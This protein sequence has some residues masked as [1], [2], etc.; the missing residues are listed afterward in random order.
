[1]FEFSETRLQKVS[2]HRVGNKTNN[3]DLILSKSE[4]DANDSMVRS[5]LSKYFLSSFTIPEFYSFT[6][7]NEDFQLNPLFIYATQIFQG[8]SFHLNSINIAKHLF[9]LSLHPQIKSGDVFVAYFNEVNVSGEITDAIGIFKS[10]NKQAF[11]RLNAGNDGF[12]INWEEGI[13][14]EKLDK[15][16]LILNSNQEHGLKICMV[17]KTSKGND[18]QFWK[19][20]FLQIKPI[21]DEY[22]QTKAF[23]DLTKNFVTKQ[24]QQDFEVTKADQIDL[25]N[26]SVAYFKT[27]DNFD[28]LDFEKEVFQDEAMIQSF[29]TFNEAY[30]EQ[31]EIE[32]DYSFEISPQAVKKQER[33]FKSVLKLDKNFH[34]YIHGNQK[35][36][37]QGVEQDG[38]KFYKIYF[39]K[40]A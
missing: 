37:E 31:S 35:L 21:S 13:N 25:L 27:H 3:E 22:H 17:D 10:E 19:D 23:M 8:S 38:R 40:E 26:R 32:M 5:L 29:Q 30:R 20:S 16:C 1:M 7:S 39:E 2:V 9:E 6:F 24:I 15:G 11:L 33:V 14:I 36:I 18:A 34:I 12:D 4:L 28:K